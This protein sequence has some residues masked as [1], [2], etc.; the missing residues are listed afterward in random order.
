[1]PLMNL[2]GSKPNKV[3]VKSG[4]KKHDNVANVTPIRGN[5]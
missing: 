2:V 4:I 5:K 3:V 1:M